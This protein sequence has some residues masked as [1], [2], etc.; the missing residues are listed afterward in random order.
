MLH[1]TNIVKRVIHNQGIN[2]IHHYTTQKMGRLLQD[3]KG[4]FSAK[5]VG[6]DEANLNVLAAP[7]QR[8]DLAVDLTRM[9]PTFK[10]KQQRFVELLCGAYCSDFTKWLTEQGYKIET[11][12]E[13]LDRLKIKQYMELALRYLDVPIDV[14]MRFIERLRKVLS[15]YSVQIQANRAGAFA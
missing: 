8:S 3:Q 6:L 2:M 4:A 12:E 14:G 5:V 9:M 15:P 7:E 13:L 11:N 1:A 10:P